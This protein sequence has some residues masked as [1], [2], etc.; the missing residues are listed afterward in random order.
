M[1]S[2]PVTTSGKSN[3]QARRTDQAQRNALDLSLI[4]DDISAQHAPVIQKRRLDRPPGI[5][6]LSVELNTEMEESEPSLRRWRIIAFVTFMTASAFIA[7]ADF[8]FYEIKWWTDGSWILDVLITTIAIA[9]WCHLDARLKGRLISRRL[10]VWIVLAS[11]FAVPVYLVQ[12]RGWKGA[13]KLG[14]GLPFFAVSIWVYD[15][16]WMITESVCERMDWMQR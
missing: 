8:V 5:A 15:L 7:V 3:N 16:T 10:S 11:L 14:L 9:V 1:R 4:V 13:L 12:S 6:D 2:I